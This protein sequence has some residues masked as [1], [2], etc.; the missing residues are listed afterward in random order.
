M[1]RRTIGMVVLAVGVLSAGCEDEGADETEE[2]ATAPEPEPVEEEPA[3]PTADEVPIAEDFESEAE[4]EITED[5][6]EAKLDD[7]EEELE[8]DLEEAGD[9]P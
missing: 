9:E 4:E 2:L 1:M 5:N 6:Y 8:A 7:L 3:D